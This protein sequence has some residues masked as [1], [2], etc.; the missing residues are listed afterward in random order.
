MLAN[1]LTAED[2]DAVQAE[3]RQLQQAEVVSTRN[4]L[5]FSARLTL[6]VSQQHA[7]DVLEP[8]TLPSVPLNRPVAKNTAR[9]SVALALVDII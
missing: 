6:C 8:S 2:E 4:T 5:S 1:N 3:L 7:E 9:K